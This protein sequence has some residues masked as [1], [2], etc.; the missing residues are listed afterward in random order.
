MNILCLGTSYTGLHLAVNFVIH[1]IIFL[2]RKMRDQQQTI[3]FLVNSRRKI[4]LILDTVP[5]VQK[6]IGHDGETP[7]YFDQ[8]RQLPY[9]AEIPYIH[10]S[11]TGVYKSLKKGVKTHNEEDFQYDSSER[12]QRRL[13]VE[14]IIRKFYPWA[15][16]IR[17][18]GIYGPQRNIVE[19]FAQRGDFRRALLGN[20]VISRIHVHD[21]C[22]LILRLPDYNKGRILMIHATDNSPTSNREIFSKIEEKYSL[23]IPG[24]WRNEESYGKKIISL[25]C[26]KILKKYDYPSF[27]ISD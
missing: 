9:L 3:R 16:I 13:H 20:R 17:A 10:I 11:T 1:R 19:R 12:A 6:L 2:S 4:D 24:N 5:C 27:D 7:V 14:K 8:I 18:T 21:L 26:Q 25:H 15:Q 22:R 23:K